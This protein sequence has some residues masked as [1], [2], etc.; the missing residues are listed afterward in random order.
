MSFLSLK[1]EGGSLRRA[2]PNRA[3]PLQ[4]NDGTTYTSVS[5]RPPSRRSQRAVPGLYK[6]AA[7]LGGFVPFPPVLAVLY[8]CTGHGILRHSARFM[9]ASLASSAR[10]AATGGA[11]ISLPLALLLYLLLFPTK[12]PDPDD[13]FDDEEEDPGSWVLY[14]TYTLCGALL[15]TLG[16]ISV[17][18]G[19]VCLSDSNMLST[20][21]AAE[22]GIVGGVVLCGGLAILAGFCTLTYWF[23]LRPKD[24]T[25]GD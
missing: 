15:L 2:A 10:A 16:T 9:A 4:P 25:T 1:S 23:W 19:T 18:L 8:V 17:A 14:A 24:G 22:A 6:G 12:T 7:I 5:R 11:I 21:R 3:A 13:F 20:S